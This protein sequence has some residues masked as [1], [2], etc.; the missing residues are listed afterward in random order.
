ML[1]LE[2]IRLGQS[3]VL[4]SLLL[5]F[6]QGTLIAER[7]MPRLP[8]ALSKVTIAQ[9]GNERLKRYNLRRAP[10]SATKQVNIKLDNKTYSVKQSAVEVP[11]A[12][13]LIRESDVAG[14]LNINANID[15]SQIAMNT[16]SDV[17]NLDYEIEVADIA[18]NPANYAAGHVQALAGATKWS[19]DTGTPVTDIEAA[20]NIIRKKIGKRPNV[21]N[22][23][24]DAYTALRHNKEV[25]ANLPTAT[26]TGPATMQQLKDI[27][28]VDEINVGDAIWMNDQDVGADVWGNNAQ[29][30]YRPKIGAN[31]SSIS[32]A[33]PAFGF[34]N[35]LEGHPYSEPPV[36]RESVK[37][38]I[39]G[40]TF[41]RFPNI[42]FNTAGFLFTNVK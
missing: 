9:A 8:Q 30:E 2:Q 10:G 26:Q 32:L 39:Y 5:G 37:S 6:G 21:L 13:E 40:A 14:K 11:I 12:R 22:L 35:V 33:E 36:Y 18:T 3:Q 24:A 25:K 23:S 17:L 1:T 4:T 20:S 29:L 15:I 42:A 16:A 19:A 31:G 28:G 7:V 38:W 34:T 27:L 41:E